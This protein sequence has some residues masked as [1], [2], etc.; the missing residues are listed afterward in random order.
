MSLLEKYLV[1]FSSYLIDNEIK[2]EVI[3]EIDRLPENVKMLVQ[4]IRCKVE[5]T[6]KTL[7]LAISYGGRQD[8][9]E[10][11]KSVVRLVQKQTISLD[12]I[13][14]QTFSRFTS[15]GRLGLPDPDLIVRTSGEFRLSNFL[16]WQCAYAEFVSVDC[17][18]PEYT[19][20]KLQET[21]HVYS[22]RRRRF[23]AVA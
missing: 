20:E 10:T 11:C 1:D 5:N 16:L 9:I 23:G 3:G 15:T 19:P 4:S 17:Y 14:E 2:L 6:N 12:S 13:D 7:C 22:T 18:W 21:L 8:I